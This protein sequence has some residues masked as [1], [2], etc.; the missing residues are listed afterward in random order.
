MRICLL[1]PDGVGI[2]NYLYSDLL[3][4]LNKEGHQVVL[5]HSLDSEMI[6]LVE[7]R[8]GFKLEQYQ[9]EHKPNGVLVQWLREAGRYARILLN[10]SKMENSTILTNWSGASSSSKGKLLNKAAEWLGK[11][12]TT[13]KAVE[14]VELQG[15][16]LLNKS[17]EVADARKI[18]EKIKP[19]LLFCTHQ[20]VFS[21]TAAIE[22]AKSLGIPTSTAIF[23]WDNLPKGRL[24]FRVDRYLVWSQY[25]KE[26]LL[27]Y[28]PEIPEDKISITG[29]PQFD[30]YFKEE[31]LISK[32]DFAKKYDLDPSKDW[33]CFSG[34]D[35]YTS[36]DDPKFL[37]DVAEELENETGIQ[38][39]FR[40]VPVEPID[41]FRDVLQSFPKIKLI[42]PKWVQ[43]N[44]WG[45]FFPLFED[46]QLLVNLAY[47]CKVVVNM[48]STMAL[49]FSV[50]GNVG[51]YLR[52]DHEGVSKKSSVETIYQFQ[53]FRSMGDWK[54]V[55]YIYSKSEIL[56]QVKAALQQPD[57]VAP[58][59]KRWF[60]K[61]VEH[62]PEKAAALRVAEVFSSMT[63]SKN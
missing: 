46:L 23:S 16:K 59:R 27:T 53:H 54:A 25:M 32:L 12:I 56:N 42:P 8:L 55:G 60:D 28:Y 35:T 11:Q 61:I 63:K 34:C 40:P 5:W 20:R 43:G 30:F 3:E 45:S 57:Q 15:F 26:E 36:P 58:D 38:L 50:F 51:L 44:H 2:R 9:F 31:L 29:S 18:L 17:V 1:I 33:V 22:A 13:Y 41:R 10:A 24:P 7:D 48:G 19:D 47:H 52:Y 14:L 6:Q 4:I 62:Q 39:L 37:S 21:V 49:D